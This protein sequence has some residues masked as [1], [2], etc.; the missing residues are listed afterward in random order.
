[1]VS[2]GIQGCGSTTQDCSLTGGTDG[3][4]VT[5]PASLSVNSGDVV[6]KVCDKAGCETTT[7]S[8]PH[9]TH[10]GDEE[11]NASF[12]ALGRRFPAGD[13]AVT[14]TLHGPQGNPVAIRHQTVQLGTNG[15][16]CQKG[17]RGGSLDFEPGDRVGTRG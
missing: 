9:L 11:T 15:L 3:I 5:I 8:L 16:H 14:V 1:L 7:A 13:V 6:F 17:F 10:R 4:D 12:H 2:I